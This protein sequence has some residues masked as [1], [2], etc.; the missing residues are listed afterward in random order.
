MII[1]QLK[2]CKIYQIKQT[3]KQTNINST[4]LNLK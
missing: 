3:N 1:N 2:L 4:K